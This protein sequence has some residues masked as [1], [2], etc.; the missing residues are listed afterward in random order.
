M[1][2]APA[3]PNV[4][5]SPVHRGSTVVT[6]ILREGENV[7]FRV[8]DILSADR[9]LILL[10]QNRLQAMSQTPLEL[11][12]R[13]LAQVLAGQRD[14]LLLRCETTLQGAIQGRF[15]LPRP[16]SPVLQKLTASVPPPGVLTTDCRTPEGVQKALAN[17]GV[18][19]EAKLR[20]R[21]AAGER[22][23]FLEDLKGYLLDP[24]REGGPVSTRQATAAA[25]K[26]LEGQQFLCAQSGHDG[27]IFFWLPFADRSFI[28]GFVKRTRLSSGNQFLVTWRMPFLG[29]EE[30]MVTVLWQS[31]KVEVHLATGPVARPFLE[32]GSRQ[33]ESRLE[34]LG[35]PRVEVHVSSE[36]PEHLR[37]ELAGVRY[38]ESYG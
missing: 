34:E 3:V 27:P 25:L 36:P 15:A 6:T 8:L 20:D 10:K 5:I 13:Y 32:G 2:N 21:L 38:F 17:C 37:D 33:L 23:A 9:Y 29:S 11:G 31:G 12:R 14:V 19:Y 22:L 35:F 1:K 24:S 16:M 18:F 4:R 26:N 28:E 7:A 30:L